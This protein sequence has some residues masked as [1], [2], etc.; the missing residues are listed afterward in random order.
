M[1][2]AMAERWSMEMQAMSSKLRHV[3]R[4]CM[5]VTNGD[6]KVLLYGRWQELEE[7]DVTWTIRLK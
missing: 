3:G 7:E 2:R 6:V 1:A 5:R 4:W